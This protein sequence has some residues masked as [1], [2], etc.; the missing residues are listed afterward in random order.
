[1]GVDKSPLLNLGSTALFVLSTNKLKMVTDMTR[2]LSPTLFKRYFGEEADTGGVS[3]KLLNKESAL[4]M[5]R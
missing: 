3:S 1:M 5:Q 4:D 2:Y